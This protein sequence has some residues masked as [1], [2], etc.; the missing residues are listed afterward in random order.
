[1]W[2]LGTEPTLE[3]YQVFIDKQKEEHLDVMPFELAKKMY[4]GGLNSV[5]FG[6]ITF[7]LVLFLFP[8]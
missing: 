8:N 6:Q 2:M 5:G 3:P 1:M 4:F 7:P